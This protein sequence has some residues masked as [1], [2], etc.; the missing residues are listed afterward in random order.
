MLPVTMLM[1]L[2][3]ARAGELAKR[4]GPRLP[5]T[6]GILICA[7][8]LLLMSRIGPGASYVLDV[9]PP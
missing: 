9:L 4:I 5:M 6:A 3:S 7:A 8:A 2:L 1:L